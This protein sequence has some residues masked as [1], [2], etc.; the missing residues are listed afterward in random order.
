VL[1][2]RS[3]SGETPL[4]VATRL[5]FLKA[6]Q[7][8]VQNGAPLDVPDLLKGSTPLINAAKYGEVEMVQGCFLPSMPGKRKI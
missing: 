6:A 3:H 5:N 7:C 2:A 1:F 8:L 4:H